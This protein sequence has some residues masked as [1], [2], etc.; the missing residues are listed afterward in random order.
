MM[1]CPESYYEM[2]LKGKDEKQLRSAIRGLKN[3]IGHL[4]NVM[5]HPDYG[6]QAIMHP[7][8]GVRISCTREY[9]A[10]AIQKGTQNRLIVELLFL[11]LYK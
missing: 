9:L 11:C 5:E 8:E 4:K 6:K 1:I 2:N 3:E 7:S 10:R